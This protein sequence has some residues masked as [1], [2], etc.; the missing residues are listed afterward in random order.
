MPLVRNTYGKGR[1]RVLRV[2]RNP[3]RHE[4]RELTVKTMVEGDFA[5]AYTDADNSTSLCTDTVK[6]VINVVSHENLGAP[7][8]LLCEKLKE[9]F[10]DKYRQVDRIAITAHETKWTRFSAD[11]KTHQHGFVLDSNGKPF[12]ELR[13]SR[14][15]A[16][17]LRSGVEGFTF[18]KTTQSGWANFY[19][20]EYTT[21]APTDDRICS[22]SM[23]A[24]WTWSKAPKDYVLANDTIL[25]VALKVFFGTYSKSVQD[26]L[27]RMAQAALQAVPEIS[28]LS[29]ACPNIHYI[30]MNL[31][32]FGIENRNEVFLP[33]D[34]PHGQIECTV[35]R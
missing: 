28:D 29:L 10:F 18:L 7:T 8:E 1:V 32:H 21:L 25:D 11:G 24:G 12:V 17:T 35:A 23:D 3:D 31:K 2:K 5:R 15:G 26:S 34:E 33:T 9:R 13:A 27:Y 4:V 22:T 6:N 20:D 30:P 19:V 16:Q 14:D